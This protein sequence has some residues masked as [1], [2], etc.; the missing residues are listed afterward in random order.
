VINLTA[1]KHDDWQRY[2]FVY[3]IIITLVYPGRTNHRSRP[4]NKHVSS[5]STLY[6][7]LCIVTLAQYTV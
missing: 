3:Y 1:L 2:T 4:E 7:V 6:S 5:E